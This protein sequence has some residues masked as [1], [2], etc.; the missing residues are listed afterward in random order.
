LFNKGVFSTKDPIDELK[1]HTKAQA[2]ATELVMKQFEDRAVAVEHILHHTELAIESAEAGGDHEHL[3]HKAERLENRIE[4]IEGKMEVIEKVLTGIELIEHGA[5]A[6]S[7]LKNVHARQQVIKH[8]EHEE[9]EGREL[10]QDYQHELKLHANPEKRL[11]YEA[12]HEIQLHLGNMMSHQSYG[13]DRAD[14]MVGVGQASRH[15]IQTGAKALGQF[16]G[17]GAAGVAASL[18]AMGMAGAVVFE[19]GETAIALKEWAEAKNENKELSELVDQQI[20]KVETKHQA[21]LKDIDK[22]GRFKKFLQN[23]GNKD[24]FTRLNTALLS[25][26]DE[27]V[28]AWKGASDDDVD[29]LNQKDAAIARLRQDVEEVARL[30][31]FAQTLKDGNRVGEKFL[32]SARSGVATA[33]YGATFAVMA[34]A[35]G[36]IAAAGPV[37]AGV[38]LAAGVGVVGVWGYRKYKQNKIDRK[39]GHAGDAIAGQAKSKALATINDQA[40]ARGVKPEELAWEWITSKDPIKRAEILHQDL[41]AETQNVRYSDAEL[42]VLGK[43]Q[44]ELSKLQSQWVKQSQKASGLGAEA[45][46]IYERSRTNKSASAPVDY[47]KEFNR[48][49]KEAVAAQVEAD[50]SLAQIEKLKDKFEQGD[51]TRDVAAKRDNRRNIFLP[52]HPDYSETAMVLRNVLHIPEQTIFAMVNAGASDD[53]PDAAKMSQKLILGHLAGE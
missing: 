23:R 11:K 21:L 53:D 38:M 10:V 19:A 52:G 27:Q 31:V 41:I 4:R 40:R 30:R 46:K 26:E 45:D 33:G 28:E 2:A 29:D 34:G 18:S 49:K 44:E 51:G 43:H 15:T 20:Q 7:A 17:A 1:G 50:A 35:G 42:E 36:S 14:Q 39:A 5:G 12:R 9:R 32:I 25:L 16:G 37:A 22:P 8:K 6:M 48:K 13:L 24:N 3:E 47:F